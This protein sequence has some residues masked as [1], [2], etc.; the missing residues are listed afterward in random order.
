MQQQQQQG[1]PRNEDPR[2][3]FMATVMEPMTQ[4]IV[5]DKSFS[6]RVLKRATDLTFDSPLT[7]T[8]DCRMRQGE[9]NQKMVGRPT[10]VRIQ[11]R[12]HTGED[13]VT[14]IDLTKGY[15]S[16]LQYSEP[17]VTIPLVLEKA[18]GIQRFISEQKLDEVRSREVVQYSFGPLMEKLEQVVAFN[19]LP[20]AEMM[21]H[22][23]GL[24]TPKLVDKFLPA[25]AY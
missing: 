22:L 19:T 25:A 13:A 20:L 3:R 1:E 7:L 18:T 14:K 2:A 5:E 24:V 9:D 12:P 4:E 8:P 23:E 16:W 10:G 15:I 17:Y 6:E 21:S 11:F